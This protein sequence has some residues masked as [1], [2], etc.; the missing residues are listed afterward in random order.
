MPWI[1]R[2]KRDTPA[3][4]RIRKRPLFGVRTIGPGVGDHA[5]A[6]SSSRR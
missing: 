3:E 1:E 4:W 2:E 6:V 5:L